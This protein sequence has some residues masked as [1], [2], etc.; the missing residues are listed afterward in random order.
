MQ[1]KLDITLKHY[2]YYSKKYIL[3]DSIGIA[4]VYNICNNKLL[5]E[6]KYLN[7]K[8]NGK[9]KEYAG[10][11]IFEGEYLN[12]KRWNG[13]LYGSAKNIVYELKNGKGFI[14][15]FYESGNLKFE[16]EYINGERNGKGREYDFYDGKIIFKGEYLNGKRWNGK[17]YDAENNIVY[18]LI[19]GKGFIKEY[20]YNNE[21]KFEGEYLN[22][23]KNGKGKEYKWNGVFEGEYLNGEKNGK[24]KEYNY[25]GELVFE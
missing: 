3:Y 6:G 20:H 7:G 10:K 22:G 16:G 24:G 2:K 23:E 21:L 12:G 13:K 15:E 19:N 1:N 4:R 9:G 14:K 25:K 17:G 18:E 8:G 5:F 11:I